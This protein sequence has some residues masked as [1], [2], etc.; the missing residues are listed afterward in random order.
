MMKGTFL[1]LDTAQVEAIYGG[2]M[3]SP[4]ILVSVMLVVVVLTAVICSMGLKK[5]LKA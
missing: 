1:G 3:G 4:R 2:M 5:A